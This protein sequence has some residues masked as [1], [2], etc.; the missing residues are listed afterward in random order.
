MKTR[1]FV[2]FFVVCLASMLFDLRA[3][4]AAMGAGEQPL[5]PQPVR[6]PFIYRSYVQGP[7][8]VTGKVFDATSVDRLPLSDV[9][10]CYLDQCVVTASDGIYLIE[11][12]PDG[13]RRINASRTEFYTMTENVAIRPFETAQQDFALTPLSEITDVFMRILLT[14]SET[15]T[16]PPDDIRNDLDAHL[17]LEA[18]DP[19]THIDYTDRGDCTT[20]PDACLEVDYQ[21]GYGPETLAIRQLQNT[22]YYYGVLNYYA[23]YPGVPAIVD[24]QAKVRVYMEGGTTMEYSVPST[25]SG[26]FWYVFQL[27]SDGATATVIERNCI[28][29]FD[30]SPPACPGE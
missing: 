9:N 6:L 20:F 10:V 23:G 21:K 13:L 28:T 14:W 26:D 7:G 4:N 8:S 1:R 29:T 16:W 18:P 22:V 11:N 2:F 17:W 25:G 27:V 19:P 30:D 12:L 15:E 3:N 24:S 5:D